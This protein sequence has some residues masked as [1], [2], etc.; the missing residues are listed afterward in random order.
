MDA[1]LNWKEIKLISKNK[2]FAIGGHCHNHKIMS[3]LSKN[4]LNFE[5]SKCVKTI[6]KNTKLKLKYFSYP[7]GFKGSFNKREINV[8]KKNGIVCSFSTYKGNNNLKSKLFY[9]KRFM[10][11]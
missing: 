9:L 1:K 5:V 8:L 11:E 2:L 3:Y 10:Y 6:K 7:E 4:Q